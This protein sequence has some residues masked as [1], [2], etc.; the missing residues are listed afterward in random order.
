M[1]FKE[2]IKQMGGWYPDGA[3][4]Y[5]K[6]QTKQNIKVDVN[7]HNMLKGAHVMPTLV[8]QDKTV[9]IRCSKC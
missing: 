5:K 7:F 6:T 9:V 8:L 3:S 4:N 2:P 1:K